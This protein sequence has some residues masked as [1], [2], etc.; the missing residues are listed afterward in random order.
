MKLRDAESRAEDTD[1]TFAQIM[2]SVDVR[3][4]TKFL[5]KEPVMKL[6]YCRVRE[7]MRKHNKLLRTDIPIKG[8]TY[9]LAYFSSDII[10]GVQ[11]F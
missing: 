8:L 4:L 5:F 7:H 9:S 10:I 11:I 6:K 2:W 1:E 3:L